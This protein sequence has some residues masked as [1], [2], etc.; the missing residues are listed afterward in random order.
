MRSGTLGSTTLILCIAAVVGF[1]GCATV[2][3]HLDYEQSAQHV[4]DATGY[5]EL[6]QPGD[7]QMIDAAVGEL[8]ADGLTLDEAVRVCL[9]NNPS[10][11]VGVFNVGMA[12]A[13]LVQSGLLSNPS[14]GLAFRLPAGGGLS[15]ID[16]GIAQN[17]ADLWQIPVRK[18]MAGR[19]LDRTILELAGDAADLATRTKLAYF[20]V[21]AA[22]LLHATLQVNLD[23]AGELLL[24]AQRRKEAGAG[25]EV[26]V[27]LSRGAVVTGQLNVAESR[28]AMAESRRSLAL[29]LGLTDAPEELDLLDGFPPYLIGPIEVER[30]VE[31]SREAR[32]DL[33]AA[34]QA[35][36]A[37]DAALDEQL[38]LV[39]SF[40]ELGVEFERGERG[41]S[42]GNTL[43]ADTARASIAG[44]QPTLPDIEPRSPGGRDTEYSVGPSI[45]L[46]LP[47]FDQNQAQIAKAQYACA[48][49][50]KTLD[51]LDRRAVLE[52]RGACDRAATAWELARL[53]E[54]DA[55]P[56]AQR[57]LEL[58]RRAY[59]AGKTSFLE[60][61]AA[62]RFFL[63]A[64]SKYIEL[65][66]A[67]ADTIPDLE[68]AVGRP[69]QELIAT[70]GA[71]PTTDTAT[72]EPPDAG[73][74]S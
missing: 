66:Q 5:G 53:Y 72:Q 31:L 40:V 64:R 16:G 9:L 68:R 17:I 44:G 48:Q 47:I 42:E 13:D 27:N 70:A 20:E 6:Y 14:L 62:Q 45:S 25:T 46:E 22:G 29:L 58:G 71:A 3:P 23:I 51:A 7:D 32:L 36:R 35:V 61:L 54:T 43:L 50:R 2:D 63:Q 34:R 24:L 28:L 1:G 37:A 65:Q 11:Q 19:E 38:R 69:F 39:I 49:A 52:V 21:V 41:R 33:Q 18:R 74:E 15:A 67:A 60:V 8:L 26:D 57:N 10:L 12:R 4:A 30:L 59:Q 56:L 73:E 55:I